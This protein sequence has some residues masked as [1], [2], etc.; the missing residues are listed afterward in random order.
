MKGSTC[1]EKWG[2]RDCLVCALNMSGTWE[3]TNSAYKY[4]NLYINSNDEVIA[5][6]EQ[7]SGV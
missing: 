5:K 6:E 4:N 3:I 2:T 7:V 1:C